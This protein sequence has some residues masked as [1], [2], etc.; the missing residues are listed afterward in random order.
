MEERRCETSGTTHAEPRNAA[1]ERGRGAHEH[2]QRMPG[3]ITGA[4]FLYMT[5]ELA[6]QV[7]A[8]RPYRHHQ[9]DGRLARRRVRRLDL[10]VMRLRGRDAEHIPDGFQLLSVYAAPSTC[11]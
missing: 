6:H 1:E 3:R 8:R 9:L 11:D 5:R 7:R 10:D 4:D 2:V